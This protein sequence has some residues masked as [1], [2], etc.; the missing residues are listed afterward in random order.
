MCNASLFS[1]A[2][3]R[4]PQRAEGKDGLAT[5]CVERGATRRRGA[6]RPCRCA[7]I[8]ELVP[9]MP[10][11]HS[12]EDGQ[13]RDEF[14]KLHPDVPEVRELRCS[15]PVLPCLVVAH[16]HPCRHVENRG[17]GLRPC[18]RAVATLCRQ[19]APDLWRSLQRH[20]GLLE[21]PRHELLVARPGV[22]PRPSSVVG[23]VRCLAQG[24]LTGLVKLSHNDHDAVLL[25]PQRSPERSELLRSVRVLPQRQVQ[26]VE[27]E[28]HRIVPHA[29]APE[30]NR[31]AA[32]PRQ[33]HLVAHAACARVEDDERQGIRIARGDGVLAI[34]ARQAG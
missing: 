33:P 20:G 10:R 4:N 12:R 2:L 8:D 13:R 5:P 27:N 30:C 31:Q 7:V 22:S 15:A 14:F 26:A 29:C 34:V 11:L 9:R 1:S 18:R 24:V 6:L 32:P 25:M 23:A 19:Q 17:P 21:V 3:Q 16:A 28:D